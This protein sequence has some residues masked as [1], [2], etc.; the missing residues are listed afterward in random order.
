MAV[1][2]RFSWDGGLG[3]SFWASNPKEDLV[4]ILLTQRAW[5]S[6]AP[7]TVCRDFWALAYQTIDD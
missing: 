7:P 4:G 5:T 3:T 2:G 6:P 1:P